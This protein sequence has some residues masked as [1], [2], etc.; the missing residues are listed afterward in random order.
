MVWFLPIIIIGGLFFPVLGYLVFL[1]MIF[2]LILSYFKGRFWCAHLCPRGSFLDLVLSKV[3][4]GKRIP[5]IFLKPV[6]KWVVFG[7]V[8]AFF[9]FQ[10]IVTEK[11]VASVGFVFVR[12]CLV[13]T[14][15]AIVI[16]IP[17]KARAWC[18]IC[19][20]GTLQ[21]K[22]HTLKRRDNEKEKD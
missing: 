17:T 18:A 6:F 16:G 10:L 19:P 7:I 1:M 13:T 5:K 14:L 22:I 15:I 21:A 4:R 20:M 12:M 9:I 11:T 2:F 8:I 3:S